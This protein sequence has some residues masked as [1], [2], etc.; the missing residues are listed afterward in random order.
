[1]YSVNNTKLTVESSVSQSVPSSQSNQSESSYDH[2]ASSA[3]SCCHPPPHKLSIG[4]N[5]S[6]LNL[7][8]EV[9]SGMWEKAEKLIS[10][11]RGLQ[12]AASSDNSAWSV[13]SFSSPV[14]HFV[15]S[16]ESGQFMCDAQ[17]PQWVSLKICS[18]TLAVAEKTGQLSPFLHWYTTASQQ[19]NV[20]SVGMLNIPKGR[21]Q[22]GSIPKRKRARKTAPEPK[23]ITCRPSLTTSTSSV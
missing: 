21:G 5:D 12:Q 6:G 19:I 14:P 3:S 17:C 20:T 15:T 9:L 2:Q 16:K 10:M 23:Q 7:H 8:K 22:K 1:M 4:A 18:H 13:Q 11:E